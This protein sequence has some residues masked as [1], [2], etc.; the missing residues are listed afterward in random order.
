MPVIENI[1]VLFT[2]LVGSTELVSSLSP[3]AGDEIRRRHFSSLRRAIADTGGTELKNLGDGVMVV[4]STASAALACAV[5]MQ[6]AVDRDNRMAEHPLGLRIGLSGGEVSRDTDDYFGDPVIEAARLC[7]RADGGQIL[8]A[9]LVRA[10]AGRWVRLDFL[11]LGEIK[12]KGLPDPVATLALQWEPL[13]VVDPITP[14]P[15]PGRL[16]VRPGLGVVGRQVELTAI[17]DAFKRVAAG[18]GREVLLVSGEAGQGKTTLMAEAARAAFDQGALVLF[19]HSEEDL[20][21]PY[22]LVAEA[23]GHY[24]AHVS[25]DQLSTLV[26]EHGSELVRLVPTLAGRLPDLPASKAT[27]A[28]TERFLLFAAVLALLATVSEHQPVVLVLDDLQW[29]DPGSLLLLRHFA[30]SDQSLPVL[31]LGNYRDDEVPHSDALRSLLAALHRQNGVSRIELPGLDD[32]GVVALVEAA[33]GHALDDAAVDLAHALYRETDGNPF[34]VSEV[35]RHLSETGAIYLDATGRWVAEHGPDRMTLPDSV[36]EVIGARVGRLG[37]EAGRVL[38]TAAVIGRH[39]DLEVLAPATGTTEDDLFDILESAAAAALVREHSAAAGRYSF[40]HALIQHTLYDDLGPSRRARAHRRVAEALEG[41][42]RGRPDT[43]L[44]ELARHWVKTSQPADL[45]KALDYSRRAGGR[46]PGRPRPGRRPRLLRPGPRPLLPNRRSPIRYS[47]STWP[48]GSVPRSARPGTRPTGRHS[49]MP[50]VER[51]APRTPNGWWLPPWPTTAASTV[52][53]VP[54]T[55]TRSRSSTRRSTCSTE[56]I[57]IGRSC[58]PPCV[59]SWPMA[60]HSNND[61]LWP[62]KRSPPPNRPGTTPPSSGCS[63]ISTSRSR[64]QPCWSW[65]WP[66]RPRRW[67]GPNGSAIRRCCS[68]RRCGAVKSPPAP[69]TSRPWTAASRSKRRPPLSSINRSST[70]GTP[71]SWVCGPRSPGTPT[72]RKRWPPKR[73]A[74]APTA[75]NSMPPS[76]SAHN[77]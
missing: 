34:F 73:S 26:G 31:V 32:T 48:S 43:R 59:R 75:A 42:G 41:L 5:A 18:G 47:G 55:P 24:I 37:P 27:D 17:A 35:L 38:G 25:D 13:T 60:A 61:R 7:A 1:T 66:A 70:G 22:Q 12:L 29:A 21:S 72:G 9:E 15:L 40:V 76:S 8:V 68:G 28:D 19:G 10:M 54:S 14:V 56:R 62:R 50:P 49:S 39:F 45:A 64:Y 20:A 57:R 52:P 58:W 71:S 30:S 36:R 74:S 69:G 51:P 3:E 46:R 65:P 33:A 2:D 44:G 16:S 63:T 6:Q 23:L 53:S 11:P 77:S 67:P 4:F